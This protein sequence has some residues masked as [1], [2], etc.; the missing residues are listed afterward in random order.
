MRITIDITD[1]ITPALSIAYDQLRNNRRPLM[2]AAG[3]AAVEAMQAH[4]RSLP[5]RS[6]ARSFWVREGAR[7]TAIQSFDN[8]QCT[9]VVDSVEMGHKFFGGTVF[10]KA[11][12]RLAIPARDEARRLGSPRVWST[13]GDGQLVP[14]RGQGG[15]VI[16]LARG[17][18]QKTGKALRGRNTWTGALMYWLVEKATHRPDPRAFP[19]EEK[20]REAVFRMVQERLALILRVSR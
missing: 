6:G 8:D 12:S 15:R 16:G 5:S 1:A 4:Y 14:V 3:Q 13:P 2:R 10:P 9:V 17:V 20:V 11:G 7:K 18:N 19:P